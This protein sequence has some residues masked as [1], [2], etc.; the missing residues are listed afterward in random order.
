MV[1]GIR[2]AFGAAFAVLLAVTGCATNGTTPAPSASGLTPVVALTGF[3]LQGQ[4]A[5]LLLGERMGFFRDAGIALEVQGG[6]GTSDNMAILASGRAQFVTSD[7]TAASILFGGGHTDFVIF[8]CVYQRMIAA[9]T[10][11]P[12]AGI[13]T[14]PKSLE[15]KTIGRFPGSANSEL[16]PLYAQ[17]AGFDAS[18][19]NWQDISNPDDLKPN[20]AAGKLDAITDTLIGVNG[21]ASVLKDNGVAGPAVVLPFEQYLTDPYGNGWATTTRIMTEQPDLVQRF[22]DAVLKSLSYA[23]AHPDQAAA[24]IEA[25]P[26]HY[27]P[28]VAQREIEAMV[29][30]VFTNGDG[31][32]GGID[33]D[34]ATRAV[35]I[36]QGGGLITG[37]L[38]PA[39]YIDF[40]MARPVQFPQRPGGV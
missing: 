9:I 20:L 19:V 5:Y 38:D 30:Q 36:L 32:L 10:A 40:A 25:D 21:T 37:D 14:S 12:G 23:L 39:A 2:R 33:P 18:K 15:G 7:I 22:H 4:D 29:P 8:A 34:R 27:R 31:T 24:V 17:L 13:T 28:G 1:H 3:G 16:F 11:R 26:Y 35:S 6:K